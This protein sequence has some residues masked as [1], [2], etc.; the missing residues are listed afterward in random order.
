MRRS[1]ALVSIALA[2][3]SGASLPA[4]AATIG[5]WRMEIDDDPTADGLS[6]PNEAGFGTPMISAE[7]TLDASNL[8]T[9]IVPL[10]SAPNLFSVAAR[11]QGGANGINASAAWYAQLAVSSISIEYW[12]RTIENV[13]SPIRFTS[14][15]LDGI[16]ISDPNALQVTWH[17]NAAGTPTAYTMSGLDDMDAAWRHYAFTYDE[18]DGM[19]RFYVNGLLARSF[20]GPDN[21]PLVV[22]AGTSFQIGVLMDYATA[23]QG[24]MDEVRLDGTSL[25]ASAFLVPEPSS[26]LLF[27]A[28]LVGIAA[29]RRRGRG[30]RTRRQSPVERAAMALVSSGS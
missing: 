1:S 15:G 29:W 9:T 8:P 11:Y 21:S 14:G 19:A 20:D 27:G 28:G 26:C 24:T 17:V 2:L 16:V 13:A 7:A 5:Y 4:A 22:L 6:V 12:A 10:T 23:G 25:A 30:R 18:T 3:A